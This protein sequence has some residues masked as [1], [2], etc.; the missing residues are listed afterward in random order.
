[1][2]ADHGETAS[3]TY[4]DFGRRYTEVFIIIIPRAARATFT[5]AGIDLK[6]LHGKCVRARGVLFSS[7]RPAIEIREPASLEIIADN[8]T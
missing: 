6:T 7:G 2:G 3:R 1:V 8:D 5:A 4:L